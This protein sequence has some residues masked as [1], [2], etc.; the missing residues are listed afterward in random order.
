MFQC[1]YFI[2]LQN[3]RLTNTLN[4]SRRR[5]FTFVTA[6]AKREVVR[7]FVYTLTSIALGIS[8]KVIFTEQ[9]EYCRFVSSTNV[10]WLFL[11]IGYIK[12]ASVKLFIEQFH[13]KSIYFY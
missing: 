6:F 2:Y 5:C 12:L 3:R 4:Y 13:R 1:S 11:N 8:V 10:K 7:I 9:P